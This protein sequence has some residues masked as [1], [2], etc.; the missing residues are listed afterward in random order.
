VTAAGAE[1]FVGRDD[2]LAALEQAWSGVRRGSPRLVLVTGDAGIGKS[3]LVAR[4]LDGRTGALVLRGGCFGLVSAE[5]PYAP[6]VQALRPLAEVPDAAPLCAALTG[7]GEP[8]PGD[9]TRWAQSRLFETTLRLLGGLSRERPVVLALEDVHWAD[10]ASLD[11]PAAAVP[12][13]VADAAHQRRVAPRRPGRPAEVVPVE[14]GVGE[15]GVQHRRTAAAAGARYRHAGHG[16]AAGQNV[17][18][19]RDPGQQLTAGGVPGR[20]GRG[21]QGHGH[22][23]SPR[24]SG[25][26]SSWP[27]SSRQARDRGVRSIP[28]RAAAQ[29]RCTS[30]KAA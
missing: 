6:V 7:S 20:D 4:F 5:L 1:P 28:S 27:A 2:A 25:R 16:G 10:R 14:Q 19:R 29:A 18:L 21:R 11:L 30:G 8:A 23:S 12:Q 26:R 17:H 15:C 13:Q 24:A 3:T 22:S 9:A